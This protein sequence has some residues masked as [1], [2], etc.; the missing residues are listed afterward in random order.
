MWH[1]LAMFRLIYQL[2]TFYNYQEKITSEILHDHAMQQCF[3]VFMAHLV[4]D[5]VDT[6]IRWWWWDVAT[7]N[8][9]NL[10]DST[11]IC[12]IYIYSKMLNS[13]AN[14]ILINFI[15]FYIRESFQFHHFHDRLNMLKQ[16]LC[17][18][19]VNFTRVL[20]HSAISISH[21]KLLLLLNVAQGK[22]RQ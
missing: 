7:A 22:G 13:S 19:D 4:T 15:K 5:N 2:S 20:T 16:H 8:M 9:Y 14:E 11:W 3:I 12:C 17:L 6:T 18:D 1:Q 21:V 10:F